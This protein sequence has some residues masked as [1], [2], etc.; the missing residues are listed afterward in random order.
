[1]MF[2]IAKQ[3]A[4]TYANLIPLFVAGIFYYVFNFLVAFVMELIEKRLS[5]YK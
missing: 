5:Y 4:A 1:E 2:T 3:I